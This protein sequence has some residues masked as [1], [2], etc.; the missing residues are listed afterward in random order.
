MEDARNQK[1]SVTENKDAYLKALYEVEESIDDPALLAEIA[2]NLH[3]MELAEIELERKMSI[4]NEKLEVEKE[5]L[6]VDK[7]KN[8]LERKSGKRRLIADI[9]RGLLLAGVSVWG[10]LYTTSYERTDS[11]T[12]TAGKAFS[13]SISDLFKK[14]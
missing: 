10:T 11:Y 2:K 9:G 5:R 8:E 4:E 1:R 3:E 14:S 6:E 7:D 13:R 12:S